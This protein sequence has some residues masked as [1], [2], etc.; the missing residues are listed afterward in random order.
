[1]CVC[2]NVEWSYFA[3]YISNFFLVPV[4]QYVFMTVNECHQ[5]PVVLLYLLHKVSCGSQCN[6]AKVLGAVPQVL[7]LIYANRF[8][9]ENN[10]KN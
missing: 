2:I 9:L 8:D 1:M 4:T 3:L 10:V 7:Q 6:L 5:N